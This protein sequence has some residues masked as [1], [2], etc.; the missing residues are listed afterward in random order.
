MWY[1]SVYIHAWKHRHCY[2]TPRRP[3]ITPPPPHCIGYTQ[4]WG[5]YMYTCMQDFPH[6]CMPIW[7][8]WEPDG[9]LTVSGSRLPCYCRSW[10]HLGSFGW[11]HCSASWLQ[12]SYLHTHAQ[13]GWVLLCTCETG[14]ELGV[15]ER[16]KRRE[17]GRMQQFIV[18]KN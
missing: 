6:T 3:A 9:T 4:S 14:R 8:P 11:L 12:E 15:G 2:I 18:L 17:G 1:G 10:R 16:A 5:T 13:I 7:L